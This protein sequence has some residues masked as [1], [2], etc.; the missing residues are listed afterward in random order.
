MLRWL[1]FGLALAFA[2]SVVQAEALDCQVVGSWPFGSSLAV[3]LDS[4]RHLAYLGSGGGVYVLDVSDPSEPH[5]LSDDIRTSGY[6]RD[7]CLQSNLLYVASSDAGLEVW[8]VTNDSMPIPVTR[9]DLPGPAYGITVQDSLVFVAERGVGLRI[10]NVANPRKPKVMGCWRGTAYAHDVDVS[11]S[12]AFVA[13]DRDGLIVVKVSDLLNPQ[14]IGRCT[15]RSNVRAVEVLGPYAFAANTARGLQVVDVSD[16]REPAI[17]AELDPSRSVYGMAMAGDCVY[18]AAQELCIIDVADPLHPRLMSASDVYGNPHAVALAGGRAYVASGWAGLNVFSVTD[19]EHP[20]EI[21][22][23][24]PCGSIWD[25]AVQTHYAYAVCDYG[26]VVLDVGNETWPVLVGSCSMPG[27]S[28]EEITVHGDFAFLS[29]NGEGFYVVDVSSPCQPVVVAYELQQFWIDNIAVQD[30]L[31]YC[32]GDGLAVVDIADPADPLLLSFSDEYYE[33]LDLVVGGATAY[34]LNDESFIIMDVAD[35][36]HPTLVASCP[37]TYDY[38]VAICVQDSFAYVV[39]EC[40]SL[41]VVN[42]ADPRHPRVVGLCPSR[43]IAVGMC[44]QGRYAYV[45]V[46]YLGLVVYDLE[47]PTD[48]REVSVLPLDGETYALD[49]VGSTAYVVTPSTGLQIC[50]LILDGSGGSATAGKQPDRREATY[51]N[52]ILDAP[53]DGSLPRPAVFDLAGRHVMTLAPGPN[54]VTGLQPGVY[55]LRRPLGTHRF[56]VVR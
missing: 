34:V 26:L 56:I 32:G 39:L 45:G 23:F 27:S 51:V 1:A 5:E 7:I 54:D 11:D 40:E 47:R 9:L 35:P 41:Y 30:S 25:V 3:A 4:S 52:R 12:L 15:T 10:I 43:D 44:I 49:V 21:G 2:A 50:R 13:S 38:P 53:R 46:D 36:Y 18:L 8:D 19:P 37:L 22:S 55:F 24:R 31:L 28:N 6:V 16:P 20:S 14:E 42:V 29:G 33:A 48:P 17:V